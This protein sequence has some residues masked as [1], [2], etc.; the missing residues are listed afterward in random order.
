VCSQRL[1]EDLQ[2][3]FRQQASLRAER[4]RLESDSTIDRERTASDLQTTQARADAAATQRTFEAAREL[5]AQQ[6]EEELLAERQR[7]KLAALAQA[8]ELR[9]AE[10]EAAAVV[11]AA[12]L[13]RE[14]DLHK[15]RSAVELEIASAWLSLERSMGPQNLAIAQHALVKA[16]YAG[17]P[18]KE[19]KLVHVG[20]GGGADGGG[21]GGVAGLS[22]LLPGLAAVGPVAEALK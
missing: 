16:V 21:A 15:A 18:L 5:K 14:L 7:L 4:A 22:A 1:F 17:L 8:R 11:D 19:L 2:C 20:G 12:R 13:R 6:Q 10:E 9:L 3:E